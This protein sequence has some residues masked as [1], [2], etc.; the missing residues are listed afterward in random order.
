MNCSPISSTVIIFRNI[1]VCQMN[2]KILNIFG[3]ML[4][5]KIQHLLW[6]RVFQVKSFFELFSYW[7]KWMISYSFTTRR[8]RA[9]L[10]NKFF[11]AINWWKCYFT[12]IT[13]ECSSSMFNLINHCHFIINFSRLSFCLGSIIYSRWNVISSQYTVW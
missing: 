6:I 3:Q 2:V 1:L 13:Y 4:H 11:L 8:S 5:I 12:I 9:N 7:D 10:T